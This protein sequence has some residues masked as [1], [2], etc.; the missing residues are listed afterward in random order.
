[1]QVTIYCL[2]DT[3]SHSTKT[4][5]YVRNF[6]EDLTPPGYAL[7]GKQDRFSV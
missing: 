2:L 5:S 6:G 1:M 7:T 4:T 3:A